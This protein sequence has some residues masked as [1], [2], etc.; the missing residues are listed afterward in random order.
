L[1]LHARARGGEARDI[2]KRRKAAKAIEDG[3]IARPQ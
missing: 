2:G 1:S 3:L